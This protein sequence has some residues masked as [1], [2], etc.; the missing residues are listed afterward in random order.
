MPVWYRE[1]DELRRSG[2]VKIVGL[3]QEQHADRCALFL[4]WKQM[5]FPVL[6]DS[7]NRTGVSAVSWRGISRSE[8]SRAG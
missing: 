5:D 1:L 3:I 7:L 8:V 4:Q 6:V 2:D